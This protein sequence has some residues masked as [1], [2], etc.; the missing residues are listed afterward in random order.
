MVRPGAPKLLVYLFLLFFFLFCF[1]SLLFL[2]SY[3][4]FSLTVLLFV[5][6][7]SQPNTNYPGV[8][9]VLYF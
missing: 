3:F 9:F 4:D 7:V 2:L 5:F 6:I 8:R 1:F